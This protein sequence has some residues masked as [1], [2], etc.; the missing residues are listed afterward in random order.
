MYT[1]VTP[2]QELEV[3]SCNAAFH[4]ARKLVF[5]S[6]KSGCWQNSEF[7][8]WK[9]DFWLQQNDISYVETPKYEFPSPM[10][11][12]I[13]PYCDLGVGLVV[14]GVLLLGVANVFQ[15]APRI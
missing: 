11:R 9:Y 1:S 8:T 10:E 14:F 15:Q 6:R 3:V 12:S 5:P 13:T 4:W 7:L 2:L